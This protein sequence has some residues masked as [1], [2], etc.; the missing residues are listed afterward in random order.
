MW[1]AGAFWR[2]V[3]FAAGAVTSSVFLPACS[4]M[5]KPVDAAPSSSTSAPSLMPTE[6]A[7]VSPIPL[8]GRHRS[9]LPS[10]AERP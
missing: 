7:V 4:T 9:A 10:A 2:V 5:G 6:K 8:P 3:L 1:P